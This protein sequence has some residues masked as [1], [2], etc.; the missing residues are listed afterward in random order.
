MTP[1]ET[2]DSQIGAST[3]QLCRVEWRRLEFVALPLAL[4]AVGDRG[5]Q[6]SLMRAAVA[7]RS[8]QLKQRAFFP[9]KRVDE[10][11]EQRTGRRIK[12]VR[13]R[14]LLG[15]PKMAPVGGK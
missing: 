10:R 12:P 1:D 2:A 15:R 13:E 4:L 14:R 3:S 9:R 6:Q 5:R 7:A 8:A 11:L